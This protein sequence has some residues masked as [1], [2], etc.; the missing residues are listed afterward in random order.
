MLTVLLQKTVKIRKTQTCW[1]CCR[2]FPVGTKLYKVE[3]VDNGDFSR[4]YWCSVCQ[5]I[6]S[7]MSSYDRADGFSQGDIK[8]GDSDYWESVRVEM[9]DE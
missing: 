2:K 7:D 8:D 1:G 3:C 4:A 9:G 5:S 6:I